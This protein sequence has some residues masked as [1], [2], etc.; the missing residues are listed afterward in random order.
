MEK[1]VKSLHNPNF[2]AYL[3][4]MRKVHS[5]KGAKYASDADPLMNYRSASAIMGKP[6]GWSMIMRLAEKLKRIALAVERDEPVGYDDCIDLANIA[7][8]LHQACGIELPELQEWS[9]VDITT[10]NIRE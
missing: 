10:P 3:D 9:T 1:P 7:I 2:N 8:L 6:I 4:E 5:E